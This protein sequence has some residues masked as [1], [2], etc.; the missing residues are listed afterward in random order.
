MGT[1]LL[2]SV[3]SPSV[4]P[5]SPPGDSSSGVALHT[6]NIA[7]GNCEKHQ[8]ESIQGKSHPTTIAMLPDNVLLEIF[9]FYRKGHHYYNRRYV[10]KWHL[11][12]HICQ[13]WRQ[14]VFS[15]PRR[16]DLKILCT[17]GTPVRNQGIWPAF[18]III[19]YQ[20]SWKSVRPND[21]D[22]IISALEH[23]DRVCDIELDPGVHWNSRSEKFDAAWLEP[24]PVLTRLYIDSAY[25]DPPVL[26][27]NFLGRSAPCLQEITLSGIPYP[28]LPMLLLSASDLVKL[29]LRNIPLT[30]Y[31]SPEAMVACLATLPRLDRFTIE[32]LST[33]PLPDR[34]L[35]PPVTRTVL[36]ALTSFQFIGASEHLENLVSQIDSPQLN[37]ISI[38]YI[39]L[40]DYQARARSLFRCQCRFLPVSAC[41]SSILGL[42]PWG[43]RLMQIQ[44]D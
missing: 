21:Q 8:N 14:I 39:R 6:R 1:E 31:I 23:R 2:L 28:A 27:A 29:D 18:P 9:D 41:K 34:A 35:P 44:W 4:R 20:R 11:L 13:T 7:Q 36:P 17:H 25:K 16:L 43:E 33:T 24:F 42:V 32:I 40:V 38:G 5:L 37:Q 3:G 22:D 15:S 19:R 12:V 10:W 26:P 30:G